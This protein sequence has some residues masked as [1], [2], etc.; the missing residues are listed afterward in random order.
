MRK[1]RFRPMEDDLRLVASRVATIPPAPSGARAR[2][3]A[4]V[5]AVVG[6]SGGGGSRPAVPQETGGT[7]A[8]L[9][10]RV[11]VME[12]MLAVAAGFALGAAVGAFVTYGLVATRSPAPVAAVRG[13]DAGT[14]LGETRLEG[15]ATPSAPRNRLPAEARSEPLSSG[16]PHDVT[17][18]AA[19]DRPALPTASAPGTRPAS[20]GR[21]DRGDGERSLLD[22][23]RE[24]IEREDGAAALDATAEHARSYPRGVLVQEREAIAVRALVL[25]GRTGEARTRLDRFREHFPDSLLLPALESA[26]P[27]PA[28]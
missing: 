17:A 7:R 9:G 16:A 1:L 8:S 11:S 18:P 27:A 10:P 12:R 22:L 3:L 28:P 24:A 26:V 6:S 14:P 25:L 5:E 20:T 23:A 13:G 21:S 15:E 4:R 19:R 2:V